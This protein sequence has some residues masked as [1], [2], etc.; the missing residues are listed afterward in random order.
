MKQLRQPRVLAIFI[1]ILFCFL[2]V[3]AVLVSYQQRGLLRA[4]TYRGAMHDLDLM[5]DASLDALLTSDYSTTRAFILRWGKTHE[6]THVLRAVA[7]NGFVLAEYR[8]PSPMA[9]ETYSLSREVVIGDKTLATLHLTGDYHNAEKIASQLRTRLILA[10]LI[11]TALLGMALWI[12]FKKMAMAPLEELVEAR[13]R[14]LSVSN[15]ELEQEIAERIGTEEALREREE[16]I[17]LLL[18]SVAEGIYGVDLQG[19]CTFVNPAALRLLG[20]ERA[21]D[22]V[23]RQI[24]PL[25]HHTRSDG[26]PHHS[27]DCKVTCSYRKGKG[28]HADDDVFWRSDGT[29]FPVEYW[30]Q[31]IMRDEVPIGAVTAFA[32]ISDRKRSD[33]ALTESEHRYRMMFQSMTNSFALHEIILD[34][35]GKPCD[36]RFL[37]V[38]P[39]FE[40]LTGLKKSEL[41]NRTVLEV[42]PGTESSWIERYG[43]V[44]RTGGTLHFEDYSAVLKRHFDVTAYSPAAGQFAVI[45]MDISERK[46]ADEAL[47]ASEQRF[48]EILENI[49]LI[50][51]MLD[52]EGRIIL[53]NNHLLSITGWQREEVLHRNWFEAFLPP[54]IRAEIKNELFLRSIRTGNIPAHYENTIVTRRGERRLIAWSNIVLRDRSGTVTGSAS[55]GEDITERKQAEQAL[56]KNSELLERIFSTTHFSVVYLDREFNF[57]RVNAA[58]AQACGYPEDYFPGKNHFQLYPHGENEAIFRTVVKTGTPFTVRAKPFVFP[59]H[60]E[61][62]ITY[63]DWTLHPLK[64]TKGSVE[65]LL[66]VLLD[67][68]ENKRAEESLRESEEKFRT[69]FEESNDV[70]YISTPAGRFL[71]INPAGVA[72]FGYSSREELCAIDI[73]QE[74]YADQEDRDRFVDLVQ[75]TGHAKNYAV[76]M[77]RKDGEIL[78][79]AITSTAIRN[80]AGE[81]I[82]FRGI[83]RDETERKKLEDQLRQAQKMESIGT[84]AGGVAH[85][86]NNI[87][88]AISGYGHLTMMKMATND[89]LRPNIQQILEASDRAAH[90]TKDLLLFSRKQPIDKKPV[91]LNEGILKVGKFLTRVIGEDITFKTMLSGGTIPVLADAYQIDQV[92]MNLATNARD[93]MTRGGTFTIATEQVW[94]NEDF[95][96]AHGLRTAGTYALITVSDTGEGMDEETMQRIYEPF[97]TTK[98]VGKGTGLGMS[99]VYGIV[100]Q[101]DGA[102]T[103]YSE[104]SQGTTF[105]IYLPLNAQAADEQ[106]AAPEEGV[107]VGGTETIL[108]AEDD[109]TVREMTQLMLQDF[110][111]TV[112]TAIDGEEAVQRFRENRDRIKL[113]LFDLIMPKKTGKDAYD[114]IVKERPGIKIIFASGY[115]PDMV[116]QKALLEQNVPVVYKPVSMTGLLKKIRSVLDGENG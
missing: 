87:L 13:T 9:A 115:D 32:D 62:G 21:D 72:L 11:I 70:F 1:V 26:T 86:F 64:D 10:A 113:L 105:R 106:G 66:F 74:L 43:Q 8:N 111:Y 20:Y 18:N 110:G 27:D 79:V 77:R 48:R 80:S 96:A 40:A 47:R 14:A 98:E 41:I 7:P 22:V 5:A 36:Y 28:T 24:H 30:A 45:V 42:L 94:L 56:Q 35:G 102:V 101:H 49:S 85:D 75:R 109:R 59:D 69:L 103:V 6:E 91:D 17:A 51:V 114:E 23:G 90:L 108:L 16:H 37:D 82:G 55:I 34:A 89:P 54:E 71:E 67:V 107:P 50:G 2:T 44:A 53:C 52:T 99:V 84:L 95:T 81:V 92:L 58:Y 73:G 78:Y 97:F 100:K 39:A 19:I 63:W 29:S 46:D 57:I 65:A 61:W 33:A 68:T 31:P 25:I 15:Q 116:R 112:I 104:P 3:A 76:R 88:S 12:V 93:A 60:P 4:D 38:N 83:I